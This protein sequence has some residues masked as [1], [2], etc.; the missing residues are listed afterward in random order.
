MPKEIFAGG[1]LADDLVKLSN[2]LM[3]IHDRSSMRFENLEKSVLELDSKVI[4]GNGQPPLMQQV[5]EIKKATEAVENDLRTT[6]ASIE[7]KLRDTDAALRKLQ[8]DA[9]KSSVKWG[10]L[11]FIGS[12]L[13]GGLIIPFIVNAWV[14]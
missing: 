13:F 14:A 4:R 7:N 9:I 5:S 10:L 12:G 3:L 6:V 8:D 11:I 1:E 2:Q